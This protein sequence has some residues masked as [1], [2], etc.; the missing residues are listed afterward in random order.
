MSCGVLASQVKKKYGVGFCNAHDDACL[1][2]YL[3]I[4]YFLNRENSRCLNK[5]KKSKS[6]INYI[7]YRNF[8]TLILRDL[9]KQAD[10]FLNKSTK[11]F[12]FFFGPK[13]VTAMQFILVVLYA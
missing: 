6:I 8:E 1:F 11:S 7:V 2:I 3:S 4:Y 13:K 12:F 10:H 9:L 5:K